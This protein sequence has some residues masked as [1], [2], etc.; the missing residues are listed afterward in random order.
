MEYV[1]PSPV[2]L[3]GNSSFGG[4]ARVQGIIANDPAVLGLDG[5][6]QLMNKEFHL[7]GGGILDILLGDDA[8]QLRYVVEVQL[9]EIDESHIIRTIEYWDIMRKLY[10]KEKHIAVIIAERITTRFF[11]VISLFNQSVPMIAI[12]LSGLEVGGKFTLVFTKV[13]D[14]APARDQMDTDI[15][16]Q[17]ADRA[18]WDARASSATMKAMDR[19]LQIARDSNPKIEPKY[20]KG[21][22]GTSVDGEAS[23]FL[24][25]RPRKK[26]LKVGICLLSSPENDKLC[27]DA[28]FEVE[29]AILDLPNTVLSY[30]RKIS[31]SILRSSRILFIDLTRRAPSE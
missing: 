28:G 19:I 17:P 14:L 12:Q 5:D 3:K 21:Y 27:E 2:R 20:N 10:P 15:E 9:G 31:K 1:K 29:Y 4:E 11:N 22:I 16:Y 6:V 24:T 13:L 7:P 25:F 23:N 18:F 8:N 26:I 30:V